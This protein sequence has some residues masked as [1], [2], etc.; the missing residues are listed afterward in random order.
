MGNKYFKYYGTD[1][2]NC[3]CIKEDIKS[4]LILCNACYCLIPTTSSSAA[5]QK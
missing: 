4:K 2:T 5:I 1:I 3:N